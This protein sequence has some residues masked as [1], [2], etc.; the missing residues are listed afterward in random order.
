MKTRRSSKPL[1]PFAR[2]Q[3][4]IRGIMAVPKKEVE[5]E[6]VRWRANRALKKKPAG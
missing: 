2:F 3:N 1:S 5:A 4:L 6:E